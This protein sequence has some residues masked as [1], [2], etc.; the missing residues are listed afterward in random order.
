MLGDIVH[1][2][3]GV[4]LDAEHV[5]RAVEDA[6]LK[7]RQL[8]ETE[9]D[10]MAASKSRQHV[11]LIPLTGAAA[12]SAIDQ[13]EQIWPSMRPNRIRVLAPST[14][15]QTYRP[16]ESNDATQPHRQAPAIAPDNEND[17]LQEFLQMLRQD[18]EPAAP[19]PLAPAAVRP[20]DARETLARRPD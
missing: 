6:R 2:Q 3:A 5:G 14:T 11:R 17:K 10:G 9:E 20:R 12:R 16:G 13:I 4:A 1:P 19:Q 15:I 18:A 7:L 8:G